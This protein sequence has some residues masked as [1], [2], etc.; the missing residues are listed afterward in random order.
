MADDNKKP[1][2]KE[3]IHEQNRKI[4]R[5]YMGVPSQKSMETKGIKLIDKPIRP[6]ASAD[7][8]G[9]YA[10][11]WHDAKA[12]RKLAFKWS[13]KE[14]VDFFDKKIEEAKENY[15]RQKDKM[16]EGMIVNYDKDG[17]PISPFSSK[18]E[19]KPAAIVAPVKRPS[20]AVMK[21]V[22]GKK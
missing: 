3:E 9:Y 19:M 22:T 20:E 12:D 14:G 1:K 8:S 16:K 11:Q 4:V 7:S 21:K 10:K 6:G 5:S 15:H 18:K 17:H 2:T 13:D